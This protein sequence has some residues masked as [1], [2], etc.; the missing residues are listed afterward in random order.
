MILAVTLNPALDVTYRVDELR[1][2]RSH[3]VGQQHV[4]A[5]G[6]GVNVA[7]VLTSMGE[8]VLAT[9]I[10][11]GHA[12]SN[13]R[14][15]LDTRG[16]PHRFFEGAGESRRTVNV[17]EDH[18]G[19]STTFN[20]P[21]PTMTPQEWEGFRAHFGALVGCL[22]V[23][24]AV[25]SGSLPPGCPQDAYAQL[26][27]LCRADRV[28][29]LVDADGAALQQAV[30]AHPTLVKPNVTELESA[31]GKRGVLNGIEAL[32]RCGANAVV[33]S[34]G[35]RGLLTRRPDGSTIRAWSAETLTGNPTGAG[36]AAAAALAVGLSN[37][38]R[39]EDGLATA[40]AWSGA[41][42]L[43]PL[44]GEIDPADVVH[45]HTQILT[46]ENA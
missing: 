5:G 17:V 33:V 37:G 39:P 14:R 43:Q 29:V 34:D 20:E 25:L 24:V 38:R 9:G 7:A 44:A 2:G 4:R 22:D 30:S 8:P 42:V 45:L 36:D 12:G 46:E 13:L 23:S 16:I 27:R 28:G 19:L 10:L 41:A 6:K 26:G 11:G 35:P 3:R 21:G 15:D 32:R 1:V 40:V 18:G 31:T